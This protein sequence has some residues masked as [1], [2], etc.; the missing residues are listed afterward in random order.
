MLPVSYQLPAAIVLIAGGTISC[1]FGYR[2]FRIVLALSGF[3]LGAMLGSSL[4]GASDTSLMLGAA[5]VGGLVG[6]GLLFAAYFVGVALAGAGLGVLA[7][8][9]VSSATGNDPAFLVIVL[10]AVAG[11]IASMYLQRYFI[12]VGTAFSGSWLLIH[13]VMASL[14]NRAALAAATKDIWVF[15][16]LSP[17]PG[18]GWVPYAWIV[19]SLIGAATQLGWT[20]GEKGRVVRRRSKKRVET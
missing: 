5:L 17:A 2:L 3:I 7:A 14:G 1:F 15:Y 11:S 18:Q 19:L 4:F 9:L 13:G 12:I 20:G 8:H 16:P 10:C 6:A